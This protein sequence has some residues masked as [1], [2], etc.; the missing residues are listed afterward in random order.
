MTPNRRTFSLAAAAAV[1]A[2]TLPAWAQLQPVEGKEFSVLKNRQAPMSPGKLEV[3]EFFS[4]A[5]PHCYSL[6]PY[7]EAW[8][9]RLPADVTFR[10][11]PVP[12]LAA[13]E[14]L[15][16]TYYALEST[17]QLG[18]G[19]TAVFAAIHVHKLRLSKA[20]DVADVVAKAGGDRAKFLSA[21]NSFGVSSWVNRA[22][23]ASQA[24][25]LEG[26][27]LLAIGGRFLTSPAQAG[28]QQQTLTV[29]DA[30]IARARKG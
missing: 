23:A 20:E 5:C 7:V 28:G 9:K 13:P 10:R 3:L 12:F 24:Y 16:R 29:A 18:V 27:P 11:V 6:D 14:L 2:S 25:E 4:Y 15:Q 17:G 8:L 19:H 30:L 21:F 22:K 1:A 26:V